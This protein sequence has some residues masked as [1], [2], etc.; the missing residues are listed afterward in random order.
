M[1]PSTFDY[2][3]PTS[4]NAAVELLAARP[5][6]LFTAGSYK[7]LID[8]KMRRVQVGTLVDLRRLTELYASAATA[9][10]LEIGAMVSLN[11]IMQHE[12]VL[13]SYPALAEAAGQTG[14]AQIRNIAALGGTLAYDASRSDTAAALLALDAVVYTHHT[15]GQGVYDAASFFAADGKAA[16]RHDEIIT[17]IA[18]PQPLGRSAYEKYAHPASLEALIGAAASVA[19][20]ASGTVTACRAAVSGTVRQAKRLAGVEAAL[21]G[22]Q[23][24]ASAAADA[25]SYAAEGVE[26]EPHDD[27]S[28]EYRAHRLGVMV[29]RLLRRL[30]G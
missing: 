21:V 11:A 2:A 1:L 24:T 5:D 14:D 7:L 26:W 3:A 10:G 6:A 20:D 25:A 12:M 19:L 17:M 28:A 18:L 15:K 9:S 4:I 30:V 27:V 13:A 16:L 22:R 23:F 8:L 29:G